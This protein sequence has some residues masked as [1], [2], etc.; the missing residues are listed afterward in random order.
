MLTLEDV[1][2]RA[3]DFALSADLSFEAPGRVAI[4]G[5]S[6]AGKSTLL[7]AVAGFRTLASGRVLWN[8][9]DISG[10]PPGKR[11]VA[12]LFQDNNLFPHLSLSE[13]LALAIRP[14]GGRLDR[15]E[16]QRRDAALAR[17]GLD[18]LGQRRPG[19]VSG[20][21]QSRAALARVI[22]QDRPVML[23]DEPFAALG[24]ALK[25]EMLAEVRR[26]AGEMRML[27]LIVTHDPEDARR[28]AERTVVV[29]EGRAAPPVET[30][31]LFADPPP[32]LRDYLGT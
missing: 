1:T 4:I 9:T 17:V 21:Q 13:N 8:G 24:P 18:G 28:F 11:P 5:P 27:A 10:L 6:G 23:L 20:G 22:L 16:A 30:E 3:G 26:V 31:D 29:T 32:A 2:V 14:R 12:T 7:D 15:S 25:A 19:E